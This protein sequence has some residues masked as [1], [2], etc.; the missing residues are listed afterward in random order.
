MKRQT[1]TTPMY[2]NGLILQT[3]IEFARFYK[4]FYRF[5]DHGEYCEIRYENY[6]P[7]RGNAL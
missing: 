3:P 6:L 7:R 5:G 4:P 1:L 2:R